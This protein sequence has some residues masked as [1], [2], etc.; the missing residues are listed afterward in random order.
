MSLQVIS[1]P[2]K[3][4]KTM[5]MVDW[6]IEHENAILLVM[7]HQERDR[8]I[9]QYVLDDTVSNRVVVFSPHDLQG[10]RGRVRLPVYGIDNLDIILTNMI[11]GQIGPVTITGQ[12]I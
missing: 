7:N 11:G 12:D 2:R 8:I 10:A 5:M 6:L 3:W 4:G 9:Q 1:I